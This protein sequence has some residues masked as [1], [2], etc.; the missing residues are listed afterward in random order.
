MNITV[1]QS[2]GAVARGL[3]LCALVLALGPGVACGGCLEDNF[4]GY[5]VD[6]IVQ[7]LGNG[8]SAS[9][10]R[11]AVRSMAFTNGLLPNQ[12]L[13]LAFISTVTNPAAQEATK[14]WSEWWL[15]ETDQFDPASLASPDT[16]AVALAGI[17]ANG[18]L[19]C[20]NRDLGAGGWDVCTN[21]VLGS[22]IVSGLAVTGQWARVTVFQDFSSHTVSYFLNGRLVREQVPFLSSAI[23]AASGFQL[24]G[25]TADAGV[26]NVLVTN[27]I[28]AGLI[29][30]LDGDGRP[31]ADEIHT[32]GTLAAWNPSL[33]TALVS[34]GE[35]GAIAPASVSGI[36]WQR[37]TNFTC[38]ASN[39]YY[40]DRVWTNGGLA[41]NYSNLLLKTASFTWSNITATG[42]VAVSYWYKG[43]RDVP[44][45]YATIPDALAEAL[46]G[47]RIVVSNGTYT[48][49]VVL[50]NGVSLV[51]SNSTITFS[52][53]AIQAGSE[54]RVVNGT[55]TANGTTLKGDF[56]L[57]QNWG[58]S[59]VAMPLDFVDGFERYVPGA[60]LQA[61]S[62]FGWAASSPDVVVEDPAVRAPG[63]TNALLLQGGAVVSNWVAGAGPG[64]T[65]V[66]VD[67]YILMET[68]YLALVNMMETE[69][70]NGGPAVA[71]CL[72]T[73]GY[74]TVFNRDRGGWDV[75][76]ND[77]M[78]VA[79][80]QATGGWTR[81]SCFLDYGVKKAAFL[82]DGQ[83]VRQQVPFVTAAS[84]CHSLRL[85]A[86]EGAAHLDSL[87]ISTNLPSGF[88][89][90][91][92]GD[93]LLDAQE[94]A[95]YGSLATWPPRGTV[96]K[97]R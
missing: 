31:D 74:L 17:L 30:D 27:A 73:N 26:D 78:G 87:R 20:Y 43:W 38:T 13:D 47:D 3:V 42:T 56:V 39:A 79:S 77:V 97:I 40:V 57:D 70:T 88:T 93:T 49:S 94:I 15:N 58:V 22:N 67:F 35:G 75:C 4:E 6:A 41:Q 95:R 76:S 19:V 91:G 84:S 25:G 21:D 85:D 81:V 9:D 54:V 34:N 33:V 51:V 90:D 63:S 8:W 24:K 53:L 89:Y 83:V 5:P 50:S 59:L 28:P 61:L 62:S 96:Y 48:E 14:V 82:I 44:G 69:L 23:N 18:C 10:T 92:D 65:N 37:Q 7:T 72:G 66:W 45:D 80:P 32:C 36:L 86:L 11:S 12:A 60:R 46:A 2:G 55:V 29:G 1:S 64:L 52:S 71:V 16:N 68:Q